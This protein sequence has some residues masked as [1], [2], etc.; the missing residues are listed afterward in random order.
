MKKDVKLKKTSLVLIAI[1]LASI[2]LATALFFFLRP[3][4]T[5]GEEQLF[6]YPEN[7]EEDIYQNTA[8]MSFFR[9]LTFSY[10]GVE[11]I[12]Q[13]EDY[14]SASRECQFFMDFFQTVISGDFESYPDFFVDGYF[15]EKPKFTMQMIYEPYVLYHSVSQ[16]EIDGEKV[17]LYNYHVQ[18]KIFKNNGGFRQNVGSNVA[19][20]QIYQLMKN[21][22]GE[23]KIY[24]ILDVEFENE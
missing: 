8:Y 1:V 3:K 21:D 10:V 24:R 13:K 15:K 6:F 17:D 18:Y 23:Y 20:P 5:K 7:F 16:E 9:D 14:E 19:V 2:L 11:Q 4:K 22:A 12:F